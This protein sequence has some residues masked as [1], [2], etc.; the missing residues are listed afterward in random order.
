MQSFMILPGNGSSM[1]DLVA[2][3]PR[4]VDSSLTVVGLRECY[5]CPTGQTTL[6]SPELKNEES[7]RFLMVSPFSTKKSANL[8]ARSATLSY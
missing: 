8:F 4:R 2:M 3:L 6:S 5:S 7:R 1:H